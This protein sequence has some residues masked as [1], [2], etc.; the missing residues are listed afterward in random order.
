M[1]LLVHPRGAAER[2]NNPDDGPTQRDLGSL[3][4]NYVT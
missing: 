4:L 1:M 3:N 2:S